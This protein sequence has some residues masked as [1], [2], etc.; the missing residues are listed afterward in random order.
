MQF[1][2][3]VR[4]E[5]CAGA[6]QAGHRRARDGHV[7]PSPIPVYIGEDWSSS[8]EHK[9]ADGQPVDWSE[10]DIEF[11]LHLGCG[12]APLVLRNEYGRAAVSQPSEGVIDCGME[13]ALTSSFEPDQDVGSR[14]CI[15][16]VFKLWR[17]WGWELQ[18]ETLAIWPLQV[19]ERRHIAYVPPTS[20][21]V[22]NAQTGEMVTF[23]GRSKI[24]PR[25][26]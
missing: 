4:K 24:V 15:I 17:G 13:R 22:T 20:C 5:P 6:Y 19:N 1:P 25:L 10:W 18:R 3:A 7:E 12:R 21:T 23:R 8:F 9:R 16:R 26:P 11:A 2:E 14:L